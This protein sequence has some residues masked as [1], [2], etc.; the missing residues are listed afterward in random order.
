MKSFTILFSV[1]LLIQTISAQDAVTTKTCDDFLGAQ[2]CDNLRKVAAFFTEKS[3]TIQDAVSSAVKNHVTNAKDM[4]VFIKTYIAKSINCTTTFPQT[5]CDKVQKLGENA[6]LT[7]IEIKLAIENAVAQGKDNV[8]DIFNRTVAFMKTEIS[9][10]KFFG[11][12]PCDNLK[13]ALTKFGEQQDL[14]RE[15]IW[16]AAQ[17]HYTLVSETLKAVKDNLV[18]VI[19]DF[20]CDTVLSIPTCS[21]LRDI[22]TALHLTV[23]QTREAIERAVL[24][25]AT[26]A[27]NIY[28]QTI[29]LLTSEINCE[30]ILG[31]K[32]CASLK[33][34]QESLHENANLIKDAI[35][36][37]ILHNYRR[38]SDII[39]SV[40]D[41]LIKAA[42]DFKC[43]D[44]L[45]E[46]QCAFI[47]KIAQRFRIRAGDLKHTLLEVVVNGT[48][49]VKQI[50]EV[51]L[52]ALVEEAKDLQC[53]DLVSDLVCGQLKAIASNFNIKFSKITLAIEEAI[54]AGKDTVSGILSFAKE[55]LLETVSCDNFLSTENCNRIEELT[56]RLNL[57]FKDII[58]KMKEL[59]TNGVTSATDMVKD[60]IKFIWSKFFGG[61]YKRNTDQDNNGITSVLQ[62]IFNKIEEVV[63]KLKSTDLSKV[64]EQSKEAIKNLQSF[65]KDK[66]EKIKDY[67]KSVVSNKGALQS[68]LDVTYSLINNMI[69]Q[70][71][72]NVV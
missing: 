72:K 12:V 44:V 45:P 30:A 2:T 54:V 29:T 51:T 63:N 15:A 7:T 71:I 47:T 66:L 20:K 19:S 11:Q 40:K 35:M 36:Q 16:S 70:T 5:F 41:A 28:N 27:A 23:Q 3:S 61:A 22:A 32:S 4:L 50:Y 39:K 52:G 21:K 1:F 9:C 49:S 56:A 10:E 59:Y 25:G 33:N 64:K 46:K 18:N 62:S 17:K 53:E 42:V 8:A 68:E 37:A 26:T 13:S 31:D 57:K 24:N 38:T 34:A 14:L 43:T 48:Y 55:F 67:L 69:G 65:T 60:I 58:N 6:K